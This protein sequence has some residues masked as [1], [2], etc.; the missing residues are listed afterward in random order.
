MHYA[1][2]RIQLAP[3][4][5]ISSHKIEWH[6]YILKG[7]KNSPRAWLWMSVFE[8]WYVVQILNR[9]KETPRAWSWTP[10]CSFFLNWYKFLTTERDATCL[11]LGA[12]FFFLF[13]IGSIC[14]SIKGA[15]SLLKIGPGFWLP[16]EM[17]RAWPWAPFSFLCGYIL[18]HIRPAWRVQFPCQWLI[19]KQLSGLYSGLYHAMKSNAWQSTT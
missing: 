15:I 2:V 16:R 17:P 10:F 14:L 7:R 8:Q 6:F 3:Y 5:G 4:T 13:W 9:G 18:A 12:I 1:A 19:I 11:T